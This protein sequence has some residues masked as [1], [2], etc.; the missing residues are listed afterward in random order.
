MVDRAQTQKPALAQLADRVAS[1]FILAVLLITALVAVYWWLHA[2]QR[3][4]EITLATLIVTCPCALSLATPAALTAALARLQSI[5]L[6]VTRGQ[7]L[8]TL[9]QVTHVV[10]DKTGT[11]TLGKPVLT[12][13]LTATQVEQSRSLSIAASMEFTSEHPLAQAIVRAAGEFEPLPVESLMNKPGRG[14][15]ASIQGQEYAIGSI[16]FISEFCAQPLPADWMQ[17]VLC[18][19]ASV[20]VLATRECI[21]SLYFLQDE[22][23]PDAP[24]LVS[25]LER[26]YKKVILMTGDCDTVTRNIALQCGI[27][28]YACNL[29]P[30]EKMSRVKTL[31]AANAIVLMVGDGVNDAP[32][33]SAADVSIAMMTAT[34]LAKLNADIVLMTNRLGSILD[35]L[36]MAHRVQNNIRQNFSWALGY[37]FC[38]IPLAASGLV[39]PWMAALGMSFSSLIV[40]INALRLSR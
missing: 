5:G 10:F 23:R 28:D 25:A 30:A 17:Q 3:W 6:L 21:L 15:K 31:Q 33:I 40:V 19:N 4:L 18:E 20:V 12:R 32:V 16:N 11:L 8:E 9:D 39:A 22:L 38:A 13:V 7:A 35:G 24:Q 27:R 34:S 26:Q 37:N 1:R 14:I 2:P 36:D 29:S